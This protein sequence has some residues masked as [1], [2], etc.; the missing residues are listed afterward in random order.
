[1]IAQKAAQDPSAGVEQVLVVNNERFMVPEA[2]FHPSDIG[3]NQA[4]V[5][6]TIQRSIASCHEV[7]QPMLARNVLLT[8][9]SACCPGFE[10]RVRRDLRPFVHEDYDL[11]V[12][13]LRNPMLAAWRGGSLFAQQGRF[14]GVALT[15]Q[16]YEEHGAGRKFTM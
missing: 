16:Q 2:L 14:A 10:D 12:R 6:E 8:G 3:L 5:C 1:M 4:G 15:K 9:G 11:N 13:A 7:L